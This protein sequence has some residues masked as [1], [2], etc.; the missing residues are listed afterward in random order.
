MFTGSYEH[1]VDNKGRLIIPSKFREELGE[2]FII[3][4]GLD[5]C[6]YIYPM[7][8]WESF[9]EQ[10]YNLPSGKKSRELQRYF[11]AAAVESEVDKQGRTLIPAMLRE[12]ANIDKNIVIV[13]MMGK[14]EL[15][16]KELWDKNNSEFGEID[17]IAEQMAEFNLNF[18]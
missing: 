9:L 6:L 11:L 2:K 13:G 17:E 1:I 4:F 16:D 15:W 7:E 5:G 12:R 14:I 18:M 3:T 8:K 10:L